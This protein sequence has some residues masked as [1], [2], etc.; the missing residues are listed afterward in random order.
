MAPVA[1]GNVAVRVGV[2][3]IF[4]FRYLYTTPIASGADR[5][6]RLAVK[7]DIVYNARFITLGDG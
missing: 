7:D 2:A 4:D 6:Y 3:E 1:N 5:E